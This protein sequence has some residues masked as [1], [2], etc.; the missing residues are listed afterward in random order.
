MIR[1]VSTRGIVS[2]ALVVAGL[3]SSRLD[4]Q[5]TSAKLVEVEGHVGY[6]GVELEK[7]ANLATVDS[8]DPRAFGINARFFMLRLG[9]ARTRVGVELGTRRLFKYELFFQG[10][11]TTT[12]EKHVVASQH[13][14]VVVRIRESPRINWDAGI[15]LDFFAKYSLPGLHTQGTYVLIDRGRFR[16]PLGGRI[17]VV[18]NENSTALSMSLVS[19]V[20]FKF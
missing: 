2:L 14:G 15:G 5:D 13:L 18:L 9:R 17:D 12:R 1:V 7:W 16:V 20:G 6:T 3:L 10:P 8:H 19:G 11:G 4:A